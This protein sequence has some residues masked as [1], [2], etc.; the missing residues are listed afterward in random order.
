VLKLHIELNRSARGILINGY[1]RTMQQLEQSEAYV[2]IILCLHIVQSIT[3]YASF[4]SF[5]AHI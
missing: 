5:S 1:P 4:S 3:L 2:R